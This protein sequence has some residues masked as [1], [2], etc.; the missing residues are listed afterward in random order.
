MQYQHILGLQ[1]KHLFN[2]LELIA[3]KDGKKREQDVFDSHVTKLSTVV[4]TDVQ[5]WREL[6]NRT[7]HADRN[8]SDIESYVSGIKHLGIKYLIPMR[9]CYQKIVLSIL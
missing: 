4:Q 3:N 9:K 8:S 7:K 5:E 2:A 1:S 6:Y